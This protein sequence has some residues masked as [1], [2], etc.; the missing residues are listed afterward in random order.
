MVVVFFVVQMYFIP[1][2]IAIMLYAV[3]DVVLFEIIKRSIESNLVYSVELPKQYAGCKNI[4]LFL[5]R[6]P[7]T[8]AY[9]ALLSLHI[10]RVYATELHNART[11]VDKP[12]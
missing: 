2:F 5:Y 9:G 1:L 10:A 12:N 4:F 8:V 11:A 7:N 6:A 3:N